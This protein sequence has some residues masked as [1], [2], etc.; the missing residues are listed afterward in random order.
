VGQSHS[1]SQLLHQ[2]GAPIRPH[3]NIWIGPTNVYFGTTA[4][5]S[6]TVARHWHVERDL[7]DYSSI[8]NVTQAGTVDLGT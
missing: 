8:F 6:H 4:E 3:A 1:P 5:P 7:T 2:P